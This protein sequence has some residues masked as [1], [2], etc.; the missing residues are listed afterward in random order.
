MV[1]VEDASGN[2]VTSSSLTIS[3]SA[4]GGGT[5]TGCTNL[6]AAGGVIDVANCSFTGVVGQAYALIAV[7]SPLT[8]GTSGNFSPSGPGP[9]AQLGFSVSPLAG[10]SGSA[11][12][13]QPVVEVQDVS[14][15]L[16]TTT[17][18]TFSL[19]ASGGTLAGCTN[20]TTSGGVA[21]VAGC[22]FSGVVGTAYTLT[23]TPTIGGLAAA[24]SSS[25]TPSGGGAGTQL[26]F[27][28]SP[29]A[30]ASG[31]AFTLMPVLHVEDAFG[32][33]SNGSTATIS[34]AASGGTLAGCSGLTAVGGIVT[35]RDVPFTGLVGTSYTLNA[36]SSGLTGAS[37][38]VFSPS[39]AGAAYRVVFSQQPT[40]GNSGSAFG[41][42]P[43]WRRSR[44]LGQP[45][46]KLEPQR[47][48]SVLIHGTYWRGA[49]GLTGVGGIVNVTGCTF[50]GLVGTSYTLS[51]SS[52]GLIGAYQ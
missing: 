31:S 26:V 42:E 39:G 28:V 10:A 22:T 25:F 20:L 7:S 32:N 52:T 41:V 12:V 35:S 5:L 24:T 45:R 33:L 43:S 21:S 9:A 40:A 1:Y 16:V 14:G 2:V 50:T 47:S 3:L 6:T 8:S 34:L 19:A 36:T 15:N 38:G 51:A 27:T 44:Y 23:A 17:N 46:D 18:T 13:N 30:G 48:S 29:T 37:S 11:F 4:S 49:R